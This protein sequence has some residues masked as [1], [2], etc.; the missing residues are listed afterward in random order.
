MKT[1]GR[2]ESESILRP[3]K[4]VVISIIFL[5]FYFIW[6]TYEHHKVGS[7]HK[8][9]NHHYDNNTIDGKKKKKLN[10]IQIDYIIDFIYVPNLSLKKNHISKK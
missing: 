9:R 3:L 5:Y 6:V 8:H 4:I 2:N 7:H 10:W 1:N